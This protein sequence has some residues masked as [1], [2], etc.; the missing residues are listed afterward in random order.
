MT[1]EQAIRN[2]LFT[3]ID[4]SGSTLKE[5]AQATGTNYSYLSALR[6]RQTPEVKASLIAAFCRH[7]HF[8]PIY[9]LTGKGPAKDTQKSSQAQLDRIEDAIDRVITALVDGMLNANSTQG[10]S[11]IQKLLKDARG[12]K[13]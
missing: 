4:Q 1:E 2:R 11:D 13:N 3:C 5:V 12:R 9:I 6:T 10:L 7:F 8:S